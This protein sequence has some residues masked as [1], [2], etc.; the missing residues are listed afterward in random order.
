MPFVTLAT[1]TKLITCVR[2]GQS[3]PQA[4]FVND[5]TRPRGKFP[6]CKPCVQ[7][8]RV[9]K[10]QDDARRSPLVPLDGMEAGRTCPVCDVSLDGTH[11]NR[12]F[13]SESCKGKAR[14]WSLFGLE[15]AEYRAL[16]AQ[17]GGK[18]PICRKNV[19]KWVLDHNHATGETTGAT[20]SL[21]NT[22]LLAYTYHDREIAARLLA[23]LD[24]P[25]VGVLF[26]EKRYVGPENIS[27]LDR[28]WGWS[29]A[30][31]KEVAAD[32]AS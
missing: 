31:E 30:N 24:N 18:C 10:R 29:K 26:G 9:K 27:Q 2:C 5:R 12:R 21:C 6:W 8:T 7:A 19:R 32:A 25:P 11:R 15:P 23:Y 28:M 22:E 1:R 20:C 13:C 4:E 3:K 16:I 17:T 14:R